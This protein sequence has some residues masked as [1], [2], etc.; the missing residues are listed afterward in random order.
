MRRLSLNGL[1]N[2]PKTD[3]IDLPFELRRIL[4]L[5]SFDSFEFK[6]NLG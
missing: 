2:V 5:W 3:E 6:K 1:N 4:F